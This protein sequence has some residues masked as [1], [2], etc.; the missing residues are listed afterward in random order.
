M[1][2]YASVLKAALQKF[3][4]NQGEIV[5]VTRPSANTT[6]SYYAQCQPLSISQAVQYD[7]QGID[8]LGNSQP[9]LF[10]FAAAVDVQVKDKIAYAGHHYRVVSAIYSRIEGVNLNLE[11]VGLRE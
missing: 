4:V 10:V 3:I 11:C 9:H 1:S 8:N 7:P 5:S 2:K 6:H